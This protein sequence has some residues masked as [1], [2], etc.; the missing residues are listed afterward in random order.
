MKNSNNDYYKSSALSVF[1]LGIFAYI[2]LYKGILYGCEMTILIWAFLVVATPIPE[3]GLLVGIPVK[4]MTGASLIVTQV[5]VTIIAFVAIFIIY[6]REYGKLDNI[7]IGAFIK[8][9]IDNKFV[10]KFIPLVILSLLGT[11]LTL[12]RVDDI[13]NKL[14]NGDKP[15]FKSTDKYVLPAI[16]AILVL[17]VIKLK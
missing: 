1:F 15:E 8:D 9:T 10:S 6:E 17:Y 11:F 4:I 14:L 7:P 2:T 13:S 5:I 12:E 16:M 3:A